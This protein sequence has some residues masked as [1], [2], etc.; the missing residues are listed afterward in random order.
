MLNINTVLSVFD[1]KP[2][3]LK[4]LKKVEAALENASLENVTINSAG[5]NKVTLTFHFADETTITSDPITLPQGPEGPQGEPGKDGADGTSFQIVANV[6]SSSQLPA[7]SAT[8]LGQVYSVGTEAPLD[9]YV[10][11]LENSAYTWIN[12]GPLQGPEGPQGPQGDPGEGIN[13]MGTWTSGSEYHASS[14]DLVTYEGSAYMCIQNVNGSSTPP[15]QDSTHWLLYVSKGDTG[16]KGDPGTSSEPEYIELNGLAGGTL[17]AEQIELLLES[18]QNYIKLS[19]NSNTYTHDFYYAGNPS[20]GLL[21]YSCV[22]NPSL[23]AEIAQVEFIT[24]NTTNNAWGYSVFT[25]G[26]ENNQIITI[27]VKSGTLT[28]DELLKLTNNP[29]ETIFYYDDE[30]YY[31]YLSAGTGTSSYTYTANTID[32]ETGLITQIHS[33]TIM[34]STGA[35]TLT[36]YTP[37]GGGSGGGTQLYRQ[38]MLSGGGTNSVTFVAI[39]ITSNAYAEIQD[40]INDIHAGN[41]VALFCYLSNDATRRPVLDLTTDSAYV[42]VEGSFKQYRISIPTRMASVTPL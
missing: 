31:L 19:P 28:S 36:D 24:I 18:D 2:T 27:G 22:I 7:A 17:T 41:V 3:L 30:D 38:T 1:D 12:H 35:W 33:L 20:N 5:E 16:P 8:Y 29:A 40:I 42:C 25:I 11:E 15:N 4:W 37:S 10:C 13:V 34:T 9:I 23:S 32:Q 21:V 6:S 26:G 39:T 14:N